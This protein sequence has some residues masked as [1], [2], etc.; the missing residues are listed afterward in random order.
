MDTMYQRGSTWLAEVIK[1]YVKEQ[2]QEPEKYEQWHT[3]QLSLFG[4]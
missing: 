3:Q 2:G 4:F 1:R